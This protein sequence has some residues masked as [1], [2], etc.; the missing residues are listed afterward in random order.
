MH[1]TEATD[2]ANSTPFAGCKDGQTIEV[3]IIGSHL[4]KSH[5]ALAITKKSPSYK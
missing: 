4:G 5:K 3:K 1:I 2:D